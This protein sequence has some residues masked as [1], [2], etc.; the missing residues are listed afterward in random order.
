MVGKSSI[1]FIIKFVKIHLSLR[2]NLKKE[3]IMAKRRRKTYYVWAC[4]LVALL[5]G[6][7]VYTY[8]NHDKVRTE[9]ID[10]VTMK[11]GGNKGD[12]PVIKADK[13]IIDAAITMGIQA[14]Q[15]GR[16][17][18][19]IASLDKALQ[20]DPANDRALSAKGMALALEGQTKEGLAL[21][22]KAHAIAP[23][24]VSVYYDMAIAYK[25]Q[26]DLD[27]SQKW[28]QKVLE[29]EPGNTWTLYGVATIYADKGDKEK[30]MI[31][32]Q[33]AIES[34]SSVKKVAREQDH[35]AKYHGD[36][37]FEELTK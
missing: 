7:G 16:Y 26:G 36:A 21:I 24:E 10:T 33:K 5:T 22:E 3:N 37:Q 9:Q 27:N 31:Y 28:F 12:E 35:F 8:V 15:E 17:E 14:Y 34:D 23:E 25:F 11:S 20:Q 30:A 2:T 13:K 4:F 1:N 18:D 29:K 32:L 19:S 6:I